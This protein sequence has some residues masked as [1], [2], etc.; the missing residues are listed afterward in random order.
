MSG[1]P[2]VSHPS[3]WEQFRHTKIGENFIPSMRR[4]HQRAGGILNR[5]KAY[6]IPVKAIATPR[7]EI[8]Q[9]TPVVTTRER[10]LSDLKETM[11]NDE[12]HMPL[13]KTIKKKSK[14]KT[15]SRSS[16]FKGRRR[17][18]TKGLK[19]QKGKKKAP[20]AKKKR[21]QKG[22]GKQNFHLPGKLIF[23]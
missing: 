8:H 14:K 19:K 15:P 17:A 18:P 3:L 4:K 13:R 6:M 5:P 11:R 20:V 21:T 12:P 22:K 7:S 23:N 1:P 9:V 2:Y 10:A 16:T